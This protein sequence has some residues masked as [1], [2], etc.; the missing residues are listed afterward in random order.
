LR[1]FAWEVNARVARAERDGRLARECVNSAL[2][3]LE[4]FDGQLTWVVHRTASDICTD[5]GNHEQAARHRA[6]AKEMIMAIADSFEP[7]EPLRESFLR[8]PP[9]RRILDA[10]ALA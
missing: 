6:R 8:V 3:E 10:A 5:E 7:G 1:A 9:I 2:A 4:R